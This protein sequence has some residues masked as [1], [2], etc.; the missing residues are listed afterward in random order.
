LDAVKSARR[1]TRELPQAERDAAARRAAREAV[2]QIRQGQ[3]ASKVR[4]HATRI[5]REAARVEP[6]PVEISRFVRQRADGLRDRVVNLETDVDGLLNELLPY[7]DQIDDAA[8]RH[9]LNV[10]TLGDTRLR[11]LFDKWTRR[12]TDRP[13]RNVTTTRK[14]LKA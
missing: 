13:V 2:K 6:S 1:A 14:S 7:R 10:L 8:L 9:L 4:E 11:G 3:V 12:F 5:G